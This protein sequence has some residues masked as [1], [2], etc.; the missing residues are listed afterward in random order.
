MN[1]GTLLTNVCNLQ[2]IRVQARFSAALRNVPSCIRGEQE[3]M[4]PGQMLVLN[5]ID[6][7]LLT[8][9]G[10]HILIILCMN[11]TRLFADDVNNFFDI[12]R[13]RNICTAVADKYSLFFALFSH[14]SVDGLF[15]L[16]IFTECTHQKLLRSLII[17]KSRNFIRRKII[18]SSLTDHGKTNCLDQFGRFYVSWTALYTCEAGE[19]FPD[20]LGFISASTSPFCT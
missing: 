10:T 9:F 1:P 12:N 18:L 4:T 11:N 20:G 5:G 3:Q 15:L 7:F 2:L 19:A 14:L 17:Q 13:S 16:S 6:H 8:R